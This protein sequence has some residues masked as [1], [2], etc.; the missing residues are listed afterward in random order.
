[1]VQNGFFNLLHLG[2][3]VFKID[4]SLSKQGKKHNGLYEIFHPDFTLVKLLKIFHINNKFNAEI[5]YLFRSKMVNK[6]A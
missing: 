6:H 1:M 5:N 4:A 2:F 3:P